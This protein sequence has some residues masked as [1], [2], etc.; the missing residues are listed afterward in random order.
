M[1]SDQ[2][3]ICTTDRKSAVFRKFTDARK[4]MIRE[5]LTRIENEQWDFARQE[6]A[7]IEATHTAQGILTSPDLTYRDR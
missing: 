6:L 7:R 5:L 4:R 1:M 3:S 2:K